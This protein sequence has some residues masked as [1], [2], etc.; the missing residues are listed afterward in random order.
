MN[1][2]SGFHSHQEQRYSSCPQCPHKV[3]GQVAEIWCVNHLHFV[4]LKYV[5]L[6]PRSSVRVHGM[7]QNWTH[8]QL[9]WGGGTSLHQVQNVSFIV[10]RST[11]EMIYAGCPTIQIILSLN[12]QWG[13]QWHSWLRHCTTNCKV[14]GSIPDGVTGIF[15]W[16]NPS[17]CTMTLGLTQPLTEMTTRN[18]SW[19]VKMAGA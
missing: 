18:I 8:R 17:G 5:D 9:I 12:Q 13:I 11:S 10:A 14:T 2:E 7:M 1:T 19:G 3:W 4:N 15:H 6:H 16:H